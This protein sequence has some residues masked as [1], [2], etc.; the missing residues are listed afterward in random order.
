ML[1]VFPTHVG[2]F[3]CR[4]R[5]GADTTGLPHTRG[6]VSRCCWSSRG[7]RPSSPHTWGCF[8]PI[9]IFMDMERVFPT[10]VG[11][12]LYLR[13]PYSAAQGL[14]HT[15]GGVS[16]EKC[17]KTRN[18]LVFPTH[19]G[20]FPLG[21]P[22]VA[23]AFRL[24]HTRGGVSCYDMQDILELMSSPH[25]WGCFRRPARRRARRPVFPTHVGVFPAKGLSSIHRKGLPHTRGGVSSVWRMRGLTNRSSPHTWGCFSSTSS[26]FR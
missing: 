24:P 6:G 16:A 18:P 17:H 21:W 15:R 5:T 1:P 22:G 9:A 7:S 19:V 12:F 26:G 11:V 4:A 2:V 20:V 3:P 13:C 14:P 23:T 8:S 25:T 10:H